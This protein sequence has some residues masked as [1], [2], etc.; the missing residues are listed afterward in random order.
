MTTTQRPGTITVDP[1]LLPTLADVAS[2]R[3]RGHWVS[4]PILS[5]DV[6]DAA[7]RGV[8]R[9]Y[10][11]DVDHVLPD[12]RRQHGWTPEDGDVLRKNDYASL[13]VDELAELVRHPLVA[14]CA[15]RLAGVDELRLWHDQLLYKPPQ[16]QAGE[17]ANIGWH[18]DR[19]YWRTCSSSE[20]L[21]VWVPFHDVDASNGAVNFVDGSHRWDDDIALDFREHNLSTL[22]RS[23]DRHRI[24]F[25][26]GRVPRGAI[27]FH[28]CRTLHGSGPN[29]SDLPRRAIAIHLQPAD[30]RYVRSKK[31][32]GTPAVH[33]IDALVPRTPDGH[34]DY[35][36]PTM[37]PVLWRS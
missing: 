12:G 20:M 31:H 16:G 23:W 1:D 25:T 36:D 4:P 37:F 21:T 5:D 2:Y 34:P 33:D 17:R 19:H 32:D 22:D 18:T 9:L 11:G 6:L 29:T 35:R 28:H 24:E 10:A 3:E 8:E 30:N 14:A 15:A 7:E 27:S 13:L 26:T